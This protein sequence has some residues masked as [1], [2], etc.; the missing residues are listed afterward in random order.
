MRGNLSVIFESRSILNLRLFLQLVGL[1]TIS[2]FFPGC[3]YPEVSPK[4]YELTKALYSATNLKQVERL[5]AVESL[6]EEAVKAQEITAQEADYLSDIITR[7]REGD[8]EKAQEETRA[9][10]EDQIGSS[11]SQP[12]SHSH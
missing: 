8:W 5:N 7:A 4:A 2:A 12:H 6:I 11:Q 1:L 9:L 10:M 3:G